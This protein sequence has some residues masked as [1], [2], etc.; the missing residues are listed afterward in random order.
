MGDQI[1]HGLLQRFLSGGVGGERIGSECG[2][3]MIP[4]GV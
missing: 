4:D 1:R 3:Q 2:E